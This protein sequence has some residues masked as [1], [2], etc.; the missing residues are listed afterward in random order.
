MTRIGRVD[1]QFGPIRDFGHQWRVFSGNYLSCSLM[2]AVLLPSPHTRTE[3]F[4]ERF[5]LDTGSPV[6]F[7]QAA[8][9]KR[10]LHV[11]VEELQLEV[12]EFKDRPDAN[13]APERGLILPGLEFPT[14]GIQL[15]KAYVRLVDHPFG[16]LGTDFL[17]AFRMEFDPCKK[18]AVL[19]P[20]DPVPG[21]PGRS[22]CCGWA[23]SLQAWL[24]L[25][26]SGEPCIGLP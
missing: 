17:A 24:S 10:I 16:L 19:T 26:C 5:I 4:A 12:Q 25:C 22:R 7:I 15:P 21:C 23:V 3:P 2:V 18:R 6:T 14:L 8:T 13:G 20:I 9:L 1:L 11:P